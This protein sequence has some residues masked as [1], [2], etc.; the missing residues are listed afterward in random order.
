MAYRW[1]APL[2]SLDKDGNVKCGVV[3]RV[4]TNPDS[5]WV[6]RPGDAEWTLVNQTW[7]L[8]TWEHSVVLG[9]HIELAGDPFPPS[10]PRYFSAPRHVNDDG[11]TLK[12]GVAVL[13]CDVAGEAYRAWPHWPM[14]RWPG[15]PRSPE[16]WNRAVK[17][18]QYIEL[19]GNP[20]DY[21]T[22]WFVH[23][24]HFDTITKLVTPGKCVF[25]LN[26]DGTEV[27]MNDDGTEKESYVPFT[28]EKWDEEVKKVMCVELP[29]APTWGYKDVWYVFRRNLEADSGRVM[30]GQSIYRLSPEGL[31]YVTNGFL[32]SEKQ[33][34]PD[35]S[36]T[37]DEWEDRVASGRVVR[38]DSCP[39]W[40][41][42]R[43]RR[44]VT[45]LD[46]PAASPTNNYEV[47]F[48]GGQLHGKKECVRRVA[49]L[50]TVPVP[51]RESCYTSAPGDTVRQTR[52]RSEVYDLLT[53]CRRNPTATR[54]VRCLYYYVLSSIKDS[55][56]SLRQ[57]EGLASV[58]S[59]DL[60]A[61]VAACVK[62]NNVKAA[63]KVVSL[64]SANA[65]LTDKVTEQAGTIKVL[66]KTRDELRDV[67]A[68]LSG[69]I[70]TLRGERDDARF[71]CEVV[72]RQRDDAMRY[73]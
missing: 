15:G 65:G 54:G 62:E 69:Q 38:F 25:R 23:R 17:S 36:F 18:G 5:E 35:A 3:Y 10:S 12:D 41:E 11:R 20:F 61:R 66:E 52:P 59:A 53:V 21:P 67:N 60:N 6:R 50:Y 33:N 44:S 48:I 71:T 51:D 55:G 26:A 22:R 1:F 68:V 73:H 16:Q 63:C 47:I 29:G 57:I 40:A 24:Y 13:V 2:M 70:A 72:K 43:S 34:H 58:D 32:D 49:P 7:S 27:T 46:P 45:K 30:R 56:L 28:R 8:S 19:P 4:G 31:E 42:A 14:L 64:R 39:Q 9:L 37:R